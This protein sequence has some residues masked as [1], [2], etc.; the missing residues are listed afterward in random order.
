MELDRKLSQRFENLAFLRK[1]VLSGRAEAYEIDNELIVILR[2]ELMPDGCKHELVWLASFGRN[3][4]KHIPE[5]LNRA[6]AKNFSAIRFHCSSDERAV[7]RLV[8]R[9]GAQTVETIN[10][11][12]L[13]V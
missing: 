12:N 7:M 3:L 11:L 13:E 9:W 6:K 4:N 10:R 1:E 2:P 8:K 5:I